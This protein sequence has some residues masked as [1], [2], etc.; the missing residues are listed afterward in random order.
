MNKK[1]IIF[2][3]GVVL[4]ALGM[5]VSAQDGRPYIGVRLDSTLLPELLT[6]HLGL[7][8]SQGIRINNV[9][10]ASPADKAGLERDD[11]I[12][13]FQGHEVM[14]LKQFIDTVQAAG[15]GTEVA[16]EIIHLGQRKTLQFELEALR[17]VREWKYPPEPETVTSWRPGK[18]FRVDPDGQDWTEIPFD[19]IPEVD[20]E[21]KKFFNERYLHRYTTDGE[22]YTISV[23]GDPEDENTR[24]TVR[25]GETEHSTTVGQL[26][27][28]PEKYREPA[29]EALASAKQSSRDRIR[30]RP[31]ALPQPP[32]PDAYRRY[33]QD[34]T[35]PRLNLEQWSQK[36]DQML[37]KLDEQMERLQQ[38]IEEL[39]QRHQETL[40]KL[41]DKK[42]EEAADDAAADDMVAPT[43]EAESSI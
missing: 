41:L 7:K 15:V 31:F 20:V 9:N 4:L 37:E 19:R 5:V 34:I 21:V 11:L 8:P 42:K 12:V 23:E 40:E 13:G 6:K 17:G 35:I 18:I 14:E 27:A 28:L 38:R 22:D 26:E 30:I 10:S 33:F 24:V 16:L 2:I 39:E 36:K 3:A 43:E 1:R 29:R 32:K 25:I